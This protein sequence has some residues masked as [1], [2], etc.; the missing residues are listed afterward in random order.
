[1]LNDLFLFFFFNFYAYCYFISN[2]SKNLTKPMHSLT[3]LKNTCV[4]MYVNPTQ[5]VRI[6]SLMFISF[7]KDLKCILNSQ[8][9]PFC[10]PNHWVK[11]KKLSSKLFGHGVISVGS[12]RHYQ[13]LDPCLG[14]VLY[15][16]K[17]K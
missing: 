4:Y 6:N 8:L 9:H 14:D 11:K 17:K 13:F 10:N 5:I 3:M 7:C 1:M 15:F 2:Y 12:I 16:P